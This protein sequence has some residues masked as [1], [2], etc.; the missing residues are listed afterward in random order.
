MA[1]SFPAG[2]DTPA[3]NHPTSHPSTHSLPQRNVSIN[4][5]ESTGQAGGLHPLHHPQGGG[6]TA[7]GPKLSRWA[8]L[9]SD[10]KDSAVP[11]STATPTSAQRP[12]HAAPHTQ[13][14][15]TNKVSAEMFML[16]LNY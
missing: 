7:G 14:D 5:G 4:V 13:V 8:T 10:S 3:T 12:Q 15:S 1:A 2:G 11:A 9:R 6:S 16:L